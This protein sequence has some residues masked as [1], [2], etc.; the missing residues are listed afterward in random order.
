MIPS[1]AKFKEGYSTV[2][3]ADDMA[4]PI[5]KVPEAVQGFL[6]I[7][8]KYDIYIPPYGHAGDGNLHTKVLLEPGNPD[9]W[10]QAEKAV[11]EIYDLVLE[12]GGTVTGEHGVAISKAEY[13]KKERADAIPFMR[14]IKRALDPNNILNPY[15]IFDWEDNFLHQLRYPVEYANK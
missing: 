4:V 12:L 10:K 11:R 13:F 8:S 15:K 1:L 3:L 6:E 2:M 14:T 9:H 7:Q 5:S